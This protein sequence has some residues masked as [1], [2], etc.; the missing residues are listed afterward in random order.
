MSAVESV[1]GL[2]HGGDE[3]FRRVV[4]HAPAAMVMTDRRGVIVLVNSLTEQLFAYPRAA[5]IGR[6]IDMLVPERFRAHHDRYRSG[7][8]DHPQPRPMGGGRELFAIRADGS[9]FPVEIGLNP[10]ET[11]DG[12]MVLA[13]I[14]D[15]TERRRAQHKLEDALQEKTVL[16]NEIHH[17]VK[18]NLQVIA[19]LLNLQATNSSNPEVRAIL[20][21]TQNRVRAMTLT[22]QLLY[23]HKDFA[24]IDLGEYLNR[25]GQLI[26]GSYR[27]SS[28]RI[29]LRLEAP[30][31]QVHLDLGRAISCGLIVTELA[32]NAFKHAF[33]AE[34]HGEIVIALN[35][36]ADGE[37]IL[38]IA[39][40]G[41]GLPPDFDLA[42]AKSLGLQL[43]PLLADQL[44]ATLAV[45]GHPGTR[46]TL[47]FA[48][49]PDGPTP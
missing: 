9:E 25:L 38:T 33:P 29:G 23:E 11:E 2:H 20:G 28:G 42:A 18:N 27:A 16:L 40:D 3:S 13:S 49:T 43:V 12:T 41:I 19:S 47:S 48:Q 10:L 39:D 45:A 5:L 21:E 1:G 14:V 46:Y 22:H 17:R 31:R 30:P 36:A 26:L 6:S 44:H 24:R 4:E 37:V 34:R 8:F 15:I 35:V 32:T 7:F